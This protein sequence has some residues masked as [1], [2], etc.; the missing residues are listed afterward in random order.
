MSKMASGFIAGLAMVGTLATSA[1][2]VSYNGPTVSIDGAQYQLAGN[3][4]STASGSDVVDAKFFNAASVLVASFTNAR[5]VVAPID[6]SSGHTSGTGGAFSIIDNVST[7]TLLS[8]TFANGS[9]VGSLGSVN[10]FESSLIATFVNPG[11]VALQ[12]YSPGAFSATLGNVDLSADHWT[13][14]GAATGH[15]LSASANVA[16]VPE[17]ASLLLLG[18]GLVGLSFW[19]RKNTHA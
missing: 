7:L 4:F 5:L 11:V 9:I 12:Y 17:P 13:T 6:F 10:T 18:T 8:G 14:S 1:F 15:I 3:I 19:R 2:A 16:P